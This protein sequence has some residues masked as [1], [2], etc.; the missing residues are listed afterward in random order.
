MSCYEVKSAGF[1]SGTVDIQGSKNAILPIIAGSILVKGVTVLHNCPDIS[2]VRYSLE[3]LRKLGCRADMCGADIYIDTTDICD[4]EILPEFSG[5]MRSSFIMFGPLL[6]RFG[7]AV[8]SFPGGCEIGTRPID[9]HL[10]SF[11]KMGVSINV[12]DRIYGN[13]NMLTDGEIHL[14]FPSVGAT[15]NIMLLAAGSDVNITINNAAREPEISQLAA[16]LNQMGADI[17]GVGTETIHIS[18]KSDLK[19]TEITIDGDRICAGTYIVAVGMCGGK[20]M[21]NG[22]SFNALTGILD[23]VSEMGIDVVSTPSGVLVRCY[24]ETRNVPNID[25]A[26]YPGFPTDMQ[27][28][29]MALACVSRGE[30]LI[31]ENVFENRYRIVPEL[32]HM[33]A[34]ID[35]LDYGVKVKGISRFEGCKVF[36][37]ELRGG[38]SLVLAGMKATGI[39]RVYGAEY[40]E[41]G[42]E[43]MER[44]MRRLG[45]DI[46]RKE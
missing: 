8:A 31:R 19:A 46:S 2:D 10:N 36:A 18:G 15:E 16:F 14:G 20:I 45:A 40:I 41:R 21:L 17:T 12:C 9:M 22:I 4:Y 30:T 1:L 44:D 11:E 29:I 13:I 24:D 32:V 5:K 6:A 3:L 38:A 35:V 42:Y 34:R 26:P 39:T 28:Q 23:V 7:K 43:N 25:T 33:G 27:S 37:R